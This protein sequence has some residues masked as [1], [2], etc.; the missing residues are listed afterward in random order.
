MAKVQAVQLIWQQL[1]EAALPGLSRLPPQPQLTLHPGRPSRP[2]LV[3]PAAVSRRRL[4]SV[5]GRIALLHAIAH[6]GFNAINLALD[7]ALRFVGMPT[8]Y[9]LDWISVAVD[10]ARH[11]SLLQR[12]M[13]DLGAAYGGLPA[14]DGLWQMAIKTA[15]DVLARMAL[16]PR[17]LEARGLDVTPGMIDKLRGVGDDASVD[18]LQVILEE[19]VRHVEIGSRWFRHC[20]ELRALD[21]DVTFKTLLDQLHPAGIKPPL[22]V[23]ARRR[24]EFSEAELRML[25]ARIAEH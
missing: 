20:C 18:V 14:H 15:D 7:A 6:I 9:Y 22:N 24:A 3:H 23:A 11:F 2:E 21:A 12:R 5:E 25:H 13:Q 8:Q 1:D 16:V 10:E 4:G 17:V 19:E